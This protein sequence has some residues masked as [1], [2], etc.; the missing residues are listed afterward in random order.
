M[1]LWGAAWHWE[2][3]WVLEEMRVF[4]VRVL[5]RSSLGAGKTGGIPLG[6]LKLHHFTFTTSAGRFRNDLNAMCQWLLR[7]GLLLVLQKSFPMFSIIIYFGGKPQGALESSWLHIEDLS[8]LSFIQFNTHFL[9][10]SGSRRSAGA[11]SSCHWAQA[12]WHPGQ[13]SRSSHG[14]IVTKK[15]KKNICSHIHT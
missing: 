13:A 2:L 14:L 3:L 10:G 1:S 7:G 6:S 15:N 5:L 8:M 4:Y 11:S 12:G 9:L